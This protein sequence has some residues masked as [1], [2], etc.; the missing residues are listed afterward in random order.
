MQPSIFIAG[1][2]RSGS[3]FLCSLLRGFDGLRVYQEIFHF[4]IKVI[5][6]HLFG[7]F[8]E[9]ERRYAEAGAGD[10]IRSALVKNPSTYIAHLEAIN[11]SK[12]LA[13]KVFPDHLDEKALMSAMG[14]FDQVVLL[15]RNLLHSFISLEI[16][17]R[18]GQWHGAQTKG[19][20]IYFDA[21]Y[22]YRYVNRISTFWGQI[23]R[24]ADQLKIP[25]VELDY[26][27]L[28]ALENPY[29]MIAE[30]LHLQ[31]APGQTGQI[32]RKQDSRR[33]ASDKIYNYS[34]FIGFLKRHRLDLFN[35][36]GAAVP[37]QVWEGFLQ[38]GL[39][40]SDYMAAYKLR[41]Q[42]KIGMLSL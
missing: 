38:D 29:D 2:P 20:K 10:D 27:A 4:D 37:A 21:R 11:P 39:F 42:E 13:L 36:A 19:Q 14:A 8:P 5:E 9:I 23:K 40:I 26:E 6:D 35:D 3:T 24:I 31:S 18:S 17:Q 28:V 22:F 12:S 34:S 41:L 1:F 15:R 25:V 16:A 33:L 30:Q 32:T 7:D